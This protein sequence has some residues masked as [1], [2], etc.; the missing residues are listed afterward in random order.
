M[1][2]K[3]IKEDIGVN[4]SVDI[5]LYIEMIIK[6]DNDIYKVKFNRTFFDEDID[7]YDLIEIEGTNKAIGK[8]IELMKKEHLDLN[9]TQFEKILD[10][11]FNRKINKTFDFDFYLD[12]KY[13]KGKISD[14]IDFIQSH[15][16][17]VNEKRRR[18]IKNLKEKDLYN[19]KRGFKS[20]NYR[21]KIEFIKENNNSIIL[22]EDE[23]KN[24][25]S[26][27]LNVSHFEPIEEI[28]NMM[29]DNIINNSKKIIKKNM[30]KKCNVFRPVA[31]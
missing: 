25:I 31:F 18:I 20:K 1:L 26:Y 23:V 5:S 15:V 28:K 2:T 14:K 19:V 8:T 12:L 30:R 4:S 6:E 27:H 16:I 11:A 21:L 9:E 10:E 17:K 22:F 3:I 13:N 7:A 29:K 24:D